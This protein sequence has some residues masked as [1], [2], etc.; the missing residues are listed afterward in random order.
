MASVWQG[1]LPNWKVVLC[2]IWG[3]ELIIWA[4]TGCCIPIWTNERPVVILFWTYY[5]ITESPKPF[6]SYCTV[7]ELFGVW[8]GAVAEICSELIKDERPLVS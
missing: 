3:F 6:Y 1:N 5:L 8:R 7:R 4:K 2:P